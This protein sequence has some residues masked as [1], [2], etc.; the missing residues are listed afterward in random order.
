MGWDE[1]QA[2]AALA[3]LSPKQE[4]RIGPAPGRGERGSGSGAESGYMTFVIPP[5]DSIPH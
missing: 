1:I 3:S 4:A 2:W 5:R